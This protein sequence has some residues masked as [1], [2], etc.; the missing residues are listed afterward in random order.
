MS[1]VYLISSLP[2]LRLGEPPP[3]SVKLLLS[4]C[5]GIITAEELSDLA[6]VVE[7]R[8]DDLRTPVGNQW[9]DLDTQLRNAVAQTRAARWKCD[10]RRYTKVHGGFSGAVERIVGEAL[11]E[12]DLRR[13]EAA[14]DR[15]RWTL[16]EDLSVLEPHSFSR[17]FTYVVQLMI[18]ER[19]SAMVMEAGKERMDMFIGRQA[20]RS[21]ETVGAGSGDEQ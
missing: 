15:G 3:F 20:D 5:S 12:T 17:L 13:R 18:V 19:W 14:L 10:H 4:S 2:S 1:Y 11:S 9:R 8:E 21:L 16:V 7:N 6:A